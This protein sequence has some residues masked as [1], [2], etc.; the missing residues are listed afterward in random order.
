[1]ATSISPCR[2]ASSGT[3]WRPT[4]NRTRGNVTSAT[5]AAC[6]ACLP[7]RPGKTISFALLRRDV[8]ALAVARY[9]LGSR[10]IFPGFWKDPPTLSYCRDLGSCPALHLCRCQVVAR[11]PRTVPE[12][13][14]EGARHGIYVRTVSGQKALSKCV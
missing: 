10:L 1:M 8:L 7:P 4:R 6:A 3:G 5:V 14:G 11:G 2:G 13:A 9:L 12:P